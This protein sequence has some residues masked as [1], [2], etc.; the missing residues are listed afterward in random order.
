MNYKEYIVKKLN[1][2]NVSIEEAV[3]FLEVPPNTEMGDYAL[4]CFKLS[5]LLRKS[6]IAIANELQASFVCDDIIS[7]CLAVNG[8]LNFKVNRAGYALAVIKNVLDDG[9]KY[10]SSN[11]GK[12]KTVCVTDSIEHLRNSTEKIKEHIRDMSF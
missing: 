11:I 4:P 10:G 9:D 3:D 12:D 6:P 2:N 1:I 5:K 7:E 8:Y